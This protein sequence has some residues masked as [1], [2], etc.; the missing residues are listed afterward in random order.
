VTRYF[1]DVETTGLTRTHAPGYALDAEPRI[2][3]IAVVTSAGEVVGSQR[4][5]PDVPIPAAAS[6]THGIRDEDVAHAPPFAAVWPRLLAKVGDDALVCAHNAPFDGAV[7]AVELLRLGA[8]LPS[9]SWLDTLAA[10]RRILPHSP[11]HT[12]DALGAVLGLPV[13]PDHSALADARCAALLAAELDARDPAWCSAPML[14]HPMPADGEQVVAVTG[15]RYITAE[16]GATVARVVAEYPACKWVFGGAIGVDTVALREARKAGLSWLEVIVPGTVAQQP[17]EARRAIEEC[18][19]SV[20]EMRARNLRDSAAFMDRNKAMVHAASEV[21]AF[22]DGGP[23]GTRNAM[24]YARFQARPVRVVGVQG[25]D[26]RK[27]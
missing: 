17:P 16:D 13:R 22:T 18:A 8:A 2:V 24:E 1:L 25:S 7:L 20:V 14:W 27:R 26:W 21:L 3:S 19:D 12:L 11:R 6:A 4:I 9:W 15:H 23:S 5:R 10:S